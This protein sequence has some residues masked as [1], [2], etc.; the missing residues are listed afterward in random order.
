MH[1]NAAA[2]AAT[3]LNYHQNKS[4]VE[5]GRVESL[6]LLSICYFFNVIS[7]ASATTIIVVVVV[8][9]G[10]SGSARCRILQTVCKPQHR[11]C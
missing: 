10:G 8:N 9:G 3:K 5:S 4:R 11:F 1:N 6:F 7:S 2:A